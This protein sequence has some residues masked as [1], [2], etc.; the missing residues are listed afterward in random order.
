MR[1]EKEG[2]GRALPA[3]AIDHKCPDR[4]RTNSQNEFPWVGFYHPIMALCP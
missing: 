2:K 4:F 1:G 3:D